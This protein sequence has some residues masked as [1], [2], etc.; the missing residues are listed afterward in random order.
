MGIWFRAI[1]VGLAL[2]RPVV[3]LI[4]MYHYPSLYEGARIF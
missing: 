4:A 2:S 3:M 1:I